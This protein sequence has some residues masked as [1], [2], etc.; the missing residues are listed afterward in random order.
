MFPVIKLV[1]ETLPERYNPSMFNYFYETFPQGVLVAEHYHKIAGFIVSVILNE[2]LAK[3]LMIGV[4]PEHRRKKVATNLLTTL[5]DTL[6]H[7]DI[8]TVELEVRVDN[9]AAF[10][11]YEKHGFTRQH[12]LKHFYQNREDAYSMRRSL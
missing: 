2:D 8:K 12:R 6:A 4:A 10:A 3:I 9:Q 7:E 5:L 1:S 11:F